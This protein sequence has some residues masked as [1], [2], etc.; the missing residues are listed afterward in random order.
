M[1]TPTWD[2]WRRQASPL[3]VDGLAVAAYDLGPPDGPALTFLHGY[4]SSSLDVAPVLD[5]LDGW[6]L[7]AVDFPGFGASD[8]P[9]GHRYSIGACADAVEALW[10]A[11]GVDRTVLLAHDYGATVGQELVARRRDGALAVGLDGVVWCNGGVYGDL[12][13]PT[14]GQ[15]LLLDP[16]GGPELAASLTEDLFR[17]GIEVTWG[18][19]V[20]L[21]EAV[22]HEMW[23]SVDER[24][25]AARLHDLLHYVAERREHADR[26]QAALEAPGVPVAFVW[27]DLDPVSGAH[28][29]ARIEERVAGA[30][31]TRLADVGHWPPLEAPDEVA[32][33][34]RSFGS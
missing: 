25:G 31:V 9:A 26:W 19:R 6:R 28:M 7:L 10:A 32:S 22:A 29:V 30:T 34:V 12:H 27:G 16:D 18:Q 24:G 2:T 13:R 4:P 1:S 8:K 5:R 17:S 15:Q 21:A 11:T 3:A 20:P 14:V 33:A 23:C